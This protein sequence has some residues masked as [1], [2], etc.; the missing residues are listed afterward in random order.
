MSE[1]P[2]RIAF[3]CIG[4]ICR[5]PTAEG[6]LRDLVEAQGLA[7]RITTGSFGIGPWHVGEPPDSRAQQAAVRHGVDLSSL[8]AEQIRPYHRD[9]WDL[10]IPMERSVLQ[11]TRKRIGPGEIQ[12]LLFGDILPKVDPMFGQDVPDPYYND[13]FDEVF[14]LI[15]RGCRTWLADFMTGRYR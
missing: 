5:S 6:I 15:E 9:E 11:E 8:R 4:N 13:R 12:T 10:F 7:P 2:F 1:A 14:E 3:V